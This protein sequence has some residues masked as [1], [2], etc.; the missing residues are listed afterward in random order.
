[1]INPQRKFSEISRVADT[2]IA[3]GIGTG[4]ST[5][6]PTA[7]T[8]STL[9]IYIAINLTFKQQQYVSY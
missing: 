1:M 4:M 2:L 7:G 3:A 5:M 6:P 9:I 8:T